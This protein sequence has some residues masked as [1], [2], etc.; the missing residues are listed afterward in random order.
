MSQE[1]S[2]AADH[3]FHVVSHNWIKMVGWLHKTS[4]HVYCIVR[5]ATVGE[6]LY[7][8][9]KRGNAKDSIQRDVTAIKHFF[10]KN[11]AA[12]AT[13]CRKA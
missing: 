8:E 3:S 12:A 1:P 7:W 9:T 10:K 2:S 11:L 13:P 5:E 6:V 4:F